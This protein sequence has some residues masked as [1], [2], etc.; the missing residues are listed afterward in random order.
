[1]PSGL[2]APT[3]AAGEGGGGGGAAVAG[4]KSFLAKLVPAKASDRSMATVENTAAAAEGGA[5]AAEAEAAEAVER[6]GATKE[7]EAARRDSMGV[8]DAKRKSSAGK[9]LP[10]LDLPPL[11]EQ[12]PYETLEVIV[13]HENVWA[14]LQARLSA[15][16][17]PNLTRECGP[18]RSDPIPYRAGP[19]D[20]RVRL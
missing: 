10:E 11:R 1:M 8:Q 20:P 5:Q 9:H 4:N 15:R 18:S 2:P 3:G 14:N 6:A 16:S 19:L 13:N 7:N 12:L 17:S